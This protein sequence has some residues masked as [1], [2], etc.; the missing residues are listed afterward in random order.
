MRIGVILTYDN[1]IDPELWRWCPPGV[2]LHIARTGYPEEEEDVRDIDA[3]V[4]DLGQIAYATRSLIA[5]RPEVV[6]FAC[7]SGSFHE[8]AAGERAI[9]EAMTA[10][11]A[12]RAVTTSGA[13]IGA[14]RALGAKRVAV[15]TPYDTVTTARLGRFLEG[16]AFEIVS[17]EHT[18]PR[19]GPGLNDVT[20]VELEELAERIA[21]PAAE[22]IFLSCTAVPTFDLIA[23]LERRFDR[24][25]LSSAQVTMWAALA[26]AGARASITDQR[27]FATGGAPVGSR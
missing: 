5:L 2:T 11:G 6:A 16:S 27:L 22:A 23:H 26:A 10:A 4:A 8:G 14:L 13:A 3:Q 21:I 1:A 20:N 19:S 18:E 25:V 24:P 7:T 15:G 12:R 9:C 17:L